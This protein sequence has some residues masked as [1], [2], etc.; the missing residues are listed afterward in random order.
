MILKLS[1]TPTVFGV[2]WHISVDFIEELQL[3]DLLAFVLYLP[4][5]EVSNYVNG[6]MFLTYND[7]TYSRSIS[8]VSNIF[9]PDATNWKLEL[10]ALFLTDPLNSKSTDRFPVMI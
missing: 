9:A 1:D 4:C 6:S 3:V 10:Q 7:A 8:G 2:T 5:C